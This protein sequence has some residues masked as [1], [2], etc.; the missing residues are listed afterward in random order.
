MGRATLAGGA[1]GYVLSAASLACA[2][3]AAALAGASCFGFRGVPRGP[4]RPGWRGTLRHAGAT[5]CKFARRHHYPTSKWALLDA[6]RGHGLSQQERMSTKES[7]HLAY[8]EEILK[9]GYR[10]Q[11]QKALAEF[12]EME[13]N[14][15]AHDA[16]AYNA[17]VRAYGEKVR[18]WERALSTLSEMRDRGLHPSTDAVNWAVAACSGARE[19]AQA[20]GLLGRL[21]EMGVSPDFDTF[22]EALH[23]CRGGANWA[24]ALFFLQEME[25]CEFEPDE[26]LFNKALD[27]CE[28]AGEDDWFDWVEDEAAGRGFEIQL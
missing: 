20:L 16:V 26:L 28:A 8:K 7:L 3:L 27:A 21:E 24:E 10:R 11:W 2:A 12:A 19:W 18:Q 15:L 14:G 6:L 13:D 23:A 17:L 4:A 9:W 5:Q 25:R 22:A 1:P